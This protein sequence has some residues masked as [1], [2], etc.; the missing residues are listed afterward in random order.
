MKNK[1]LIG[2]FLVF[3][4][5]FTLFDLFTPDRAFS[6]WENRELE[7]LSKPTFKTVFDGSFGSHYEKYMTDQFALRDTLV[8]VKYLSDRALLKSEAG[9]VYIGD[10]ALF[11]RQ[12][13]PDLE[14]ILKNIKAMDSF[15]E[16][17]PSRFILVPSATYLLQNE[18]PPFAKVID[19][20]E[21]FDLLGV[22]FIGNKELKRLY[23]P[24][25]WEGHP[26]KKD[27][28]ENDERLNWN[29]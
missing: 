4:F 17:Y 8:K 6:E 15:A 11:V 9:G 23:M 26:L 2:V 3:V 14:K 13:E 24:E 29:D 10:D 12:K 19:E 22:N 1:L 28:Q 16:K 27:Y 20:K 5:G 18:L 21:I 25:T 7:R